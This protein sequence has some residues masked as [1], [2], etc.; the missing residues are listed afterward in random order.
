MLA[1]NEEKW[2]PGRI[3]YLLQDMQEFELYGTVR[4]IISVQPELH[5]RQEGACTGIQTDNYLDLVVFSV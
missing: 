5:Y 3:F 2:R 1:E 4:A